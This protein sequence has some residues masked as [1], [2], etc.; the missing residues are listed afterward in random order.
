MII[1]IWLSEAIAADNLRA[2]I[3]YGNQI[4]KFL[5]TAIELN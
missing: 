1:E 3:I 2:Y 5:K 4:H